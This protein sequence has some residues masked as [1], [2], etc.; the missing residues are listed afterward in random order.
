MKKHR[1]HKVIIYTSN[2]CPYCSIA[3]DVVKEVLNEYQDLF[4]YKVVNLSTRRNNTT[5]V[6]VPTIIIGAKKIEGI[7][8]RDQIHTALFS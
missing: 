1:K 8:E 3:E 4:E 7:P 6:S 5:V 2:D